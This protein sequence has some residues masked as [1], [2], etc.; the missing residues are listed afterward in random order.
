MG[1]EDG[2]PSAPA[3]SAG[4]AVG[5]DGPAWPHGKDPRRGRSPRDAPWAPMV[6]HGR[7]GRA[8][9]PG[10]TAWC[11]HG[12]PDGATSARGIPPAPGGYRQ[13]PGDTASA[14]GRRRAPGGDHERLGE[15]TSARGR[16]RAPA[17]RPP[18][19]PGPARPLTA[20]GGALTP[21]RPRP[22]PPPRPRQPQATGRK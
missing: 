8:P 12:G 22:R 3:V 7:T 20:D 15:T 6:R 19:V 16:P 5:P 9:D 4:R 14:R 18:S 13:R 17:G 10:G 2:R 1:T 11:P 21:P